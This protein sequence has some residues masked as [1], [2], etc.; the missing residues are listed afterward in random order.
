M[1]TWRSSYRQPTLMQMDFVQVQ[2]PNWPLMPQGWQ[3]NPCNTTGDTFYVHLASGR[4][5]F[6][7]DDMLQ[8]SKKRRAVTPVQAKL[9]TIEPL[10]DNAVSGVVNMFSTPRPLLQGWN[11]IEAS[12]A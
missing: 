12:P 3:R 11:L 4:I 7:F 6:K 5:A 10:P 1:L 9:A 2:E 8:K